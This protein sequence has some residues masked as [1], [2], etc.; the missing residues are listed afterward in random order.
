MHPWSR[1][2]ALVVAT[3]RALRIMVDFIIIGFVRQHLETIRKKKVNYFCHSSGET[4]STLTLYRLI[5]SADQIPIEFF[6]F[7]F[8][9]TPD[10]SVHPTKEY[11]SFNDN[12]KT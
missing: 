11:V 9:Q 4:D 1:D 5:N 8:F 3:K 7:F 10:G 12:L 6:L 2:R